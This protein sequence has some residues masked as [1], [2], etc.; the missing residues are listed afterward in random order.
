MT[1]ALRLLLGCALVATVAGGAQADDSIYDIQQGSFLPG[2]P[3]TVDSVVVTGVYFN[4]FFAQ[5]PDLGPFGRQF[6]GVWC[7][8]GGAPTVSRGDLVNL[9]GN[10]DEFFDESEILL[11]FVGANVTVIGSV[12][13][14]PFVNVAITDVYGAE[15]WDEAPVAYSGALAE[16]YEGVLVEVTLPNMVGTDTLRAGCGSFSPTRWGVY[17]TSAPSDTLFVRNSVASHAIP[18]D[19][20]PPITFIQGPMSYH[21]CMRKIMPR[22]N[23]DIGFVNSPNVL[24]AYATSATGVTVEFNRDVEAAS[25]GNT[26]NYFFL[27]GLTVTGA[28]RDGSDFAK[29]NLTTTAQSNILDDLTVLGIVAAGGGDPMPAPETVQFWTNI[30]PITDVQF[31]A[32]PGTDDMSPKVGDVV[33]VVGVATSSTIGT[34]TS[35]FFMQ[36]APGPG[37]A[38]GSTSPERTWTSVTTSSPR[39]P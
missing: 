8:T 16:N 15:M 13:L 29:V 18:P 5:E 25:A 35:D 37:T 23:A 11:N 12:A 30:T 2:S 24:W 9:E 38:S 3:V 17:Q 7:F 39:P 26:S 27:S 19:I 10:Y 20:T 36:D 1:R 21:R 22:D 6:G 33:T 34:A 14:P 31:V 28:A 32:D 4:G